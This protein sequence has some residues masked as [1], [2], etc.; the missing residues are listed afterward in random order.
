[1]RA[2]GCRGPAPAVS[3]LIATEKLPT[4]LE[5]LAANKLAAVT[6]CASTGEAVVSPVTLTSFDADGVRRV[7]TVKSEL[8]GPDKAY[9]HVVTVEDLYEGNA[10][11]GGEKD[12]R[13]D[14]VVRDGALSSLMMLELKAVTE[15]RE[16]PAPTPARGV[17]VVPWLAVITVGRGLQVDSVA[18]RKI[19]PELAELYEQWKLG[20]E[21]RPAWR[22]SAATTNEQEELQLL[23]GG[24]GGGT[25]DT[26]VPAQIASSSTFEAAMER[27][28]TSL[29]ASAD[30][31]CR[32]SQ[33]GSPAPSSARGGE[34]GG[35]K[36]LKPCQALNSSDG[37]REKLTAYSLRPDEAMRRPPAR[38]VSASDSAL[39]MTT[40]LYCE[41]RISR[42]A[43]LTAAQKGLAGAYSEINAVIHAVSS[44]GMRSKGEDD[45]WIR[46]D[47]DDDDTVHSSASLAM[48]SGDA[49]SARGKALITPLQSALPSSHVV[50]FFVT[51]GTP[52]WGRQDFDVKKFKFVGPGELD[53][54]LSDAREADYVEGRVYGYSDAAIKKYNAVP[55][56][57]GSVHCLM[58]CI[59]ALEAYAI[60]LW[61]LMGPMSAAAQYVLDARDQVMLNLFALQSAVERDSGIPMRLLV[62]AEEIPKL[63]VQAVST[64][65]A[66]FVPTTSKEAFR[67]AVRD[68]MATP[69][70][71]TAPKGGGKGKSSEDREAFTVSSGRPLAPFI[72]TKAFLDGG[73]ANINMIK[74]CY[75][76]EVADLFEPRPDDAQGN[77]PLCISHLFGSCPKGATCGSGQYMKKHIT[78]S[79]LEFKCAV[80][81]WERAHQV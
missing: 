30:A 59:L 61:A 18:L 39:A 6:T 7:S 56:P 64:G 77:I 36:E 62:A 41:A 53:S 31:M 8:F 68:A 72:M 50:R 13:R 71:P 78:P 22:W 79:P 49:W 27:A 60:S 34:G 44:A 51:K 20:S 14:T 54:S 46:H 76:P 10:Y 37:A 73:G 42:L 74:G 23:S 9:V 40:S 48:K 58:G 26:T 29:S 65:Q 2:M 5:M 28:A 70:R 12:R 3:Q 75:F 1:V 19:D 32:A 15:R 69:E 81:L 11:V 16:R 55:S 52:V 4:V 45:E 63:I 25:D 57:V 43:A 33:A 67:V 35:T 38:G 66:I 21:A 17:F 47:E 24:G 80:Q